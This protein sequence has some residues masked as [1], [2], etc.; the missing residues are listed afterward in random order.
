MRA[1]RCGLALVAEG[2]VLGEEVLQRHRHPGFGVRVGIHT[3]R[4]LLGG[5]VDGDASI[6]GIAVNIAARMD[7]CPPGG[8]R[9][10]TST[11]LQVRS[12]L[13]CRTAGADDGRGRR[14]AGRHCRAARPART[15]HATTRGVRAWTRAWSAAS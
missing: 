8:L 9:M 13:R 2:R 3:G 15:F 6:R 7:N 12:A 10:A 11:W 5:G 1:V 14:C 4:V